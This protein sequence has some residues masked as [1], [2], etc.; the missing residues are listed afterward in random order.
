MNLLVVNEISI[1]LSLAR[2]KSVRKNAFSEKSSFKPGLSLHKSLFFV[3]PREVFV[4]VRIKI[5]VVKS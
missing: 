2:D 5:F 1:S 4:L 3:K